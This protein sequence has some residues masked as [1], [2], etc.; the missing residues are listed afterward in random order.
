MRLIKFSDGVLFEVIGTND[1]EVRAGV[2]ADTIQELNQKFQ[3][4]LES[5]IRP[6][7]QSLIAAMKG[8]S[9]DTIELEFG[10]KMTGE[11]GAIFTKAGIESHISVKLK[12]TRKDE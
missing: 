12:W 3:D 7:T 9:P 2:G 8:L 11:A 6:A 10:V 4:V 1:A 5:Q